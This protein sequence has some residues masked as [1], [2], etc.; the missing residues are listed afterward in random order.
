MKDRIETVKSLSPQE[1]VRPPRTG[2]KIEELET[3][4]GAVDKDLQT[5]DLG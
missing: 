1:S 3:A 5:R 4:G 2:K